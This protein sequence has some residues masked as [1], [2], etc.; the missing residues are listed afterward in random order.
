MSSDANIKEA[1]FAAGLIVG[2]TFEDYIIGHMGLLPRPAAPAQ[3]PLEIWE[4]PASSSSKNLGRLGSSAAPLR[5]ASAAMLQTSPTGRLA[6]TPNCRTPSASELG[7]LR[8]RGSSVSG[9]NRSCCSCCSHCGRSLSSRCSSCKSVRSGRSKT[10]SV[11]QESTDVPVKPVRDPVMQ[12][13]CY[14]GPLF[15]PMLCRSSIGLPVPSR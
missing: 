13:I 11:S 2:K 9:S 8:R 7:A 15:S 12:H 4:R 10:S 14:G 5:V 6:L 1:K 3:R